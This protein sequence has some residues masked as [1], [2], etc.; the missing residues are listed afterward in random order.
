MHFLFFQS[1]INLFPFRI[2]FTYNYKYQY[3]KY[4]Q[5]PNMM[6]FQLKIFY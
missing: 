3:I 6:G 4:Y 1:L 2:L 5:E